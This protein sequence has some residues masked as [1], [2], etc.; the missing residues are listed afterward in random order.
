MRSSLR[1]CVLNTGLMIGRFVGFRAGLRLFISTRSSLGCF[2]ECA[3]VMKINK[4]LSCYKVTRT[5]L[6]IIG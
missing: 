5:S 2:R 6:T 1:A 4:A 3:V